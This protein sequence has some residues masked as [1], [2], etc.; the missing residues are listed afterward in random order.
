MR[1]LPSRRS[2]AGFTIVELMIAVGVMAIIMSAV[3][4]SLGTSLKETR[5]NKNRTVAANLAGEEM[6]KVRV[7]AQTKFTDLPIGEYF[8]PDR[9]VDGVPFK[10]TRDSQW[11]S[12]TS[13]TNA[14]DSPPSGPNQLAFI[15]VT[16]RVSWSNM[17]G[18]EPIQS[19]T[20]LSPPIKTFDNNTGNI[21]VKVTGLNG[22]PLAG[23][24]VKLTAP[25]LSVKVQQTTAEGCVFFAYVPGL[26]TGQVYQISLNEPNYVDFQGNPNPTATSGVTVG[27]TSG[28]VAFTYERASTLLLDLHTSPIG[29]PAPSG[30]FPLTLANTTLSGQKKVVPGTGDPRTITNLYPFSV[31]Y[32]AWAGDC[33]DAN[34]DF[35]DASGFGANPDGPFIAPPGSTATGLVH[36]PT[37]HAD[38]Y[39]GSGL[40]PVA[41]ATI[42]AV[43]RVSSGCTNATQIVLGTTNVLGHLDVLV[44]FG[45]WEFRVQGV[46]TPFSPWPGGLITPPYTNNFFSTLRIP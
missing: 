36:M 27:I 28:S 41:N 5:A 42:L 18:V 40:T 21:P 19:Q 29:A 3:A 12:A 9:I 38:V 23:I 43:H 46:S 2:Q 7:Q 24:D 22:V 45:D 39:R 32:T 6:D 33:S 37:L 15:R 31:G 35:Y 25:D 20:I 30:S 17:R 16:V 10:I 8:P 14:C 34:P 1:R 4:L 11:V 44:P 13:T 26:P